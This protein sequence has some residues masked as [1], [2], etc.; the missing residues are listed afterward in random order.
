[1]SKIEFTHKWFWKSRLPERKGQKCRVLAHGKMNSI[2]VEFADG[3]KVI[4]SR[5]AVRL[6]TTLLI[7]LLMT[8]CISTV[9]KTNPTPTAPPPPSTAALITGSQPPG[10][11][12]SKT[13][14]ESGAVFTIPEWWMLG[15][16]G[17]AKHIQKGRSNYYNPQSGAERDQ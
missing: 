4:T 12:G 2:L 16:P 15:T 14:I 6:I 5:Y 13:E 10:P 17:P 8:G 11:T 3:Y 9:I 7:V 1:M